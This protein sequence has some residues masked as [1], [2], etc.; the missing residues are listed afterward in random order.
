[1]VLFRD[2]IEPTEDKA[3]P[4]MMGLQEAGLEGDIHF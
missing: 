2:V 3:C 4:E 1:M